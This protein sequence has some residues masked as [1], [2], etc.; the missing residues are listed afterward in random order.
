MNRYDQEQEKN[1]IGWVIAAF[2]VILF[3][4]YLMSFEP[5]VIQAREARQVVNK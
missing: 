5:E 3:H 4:G 2:I 1:P